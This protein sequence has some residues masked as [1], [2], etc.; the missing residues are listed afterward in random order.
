[1]QGQGE[2]RKFIPDEYPM[3]DYPSEKWWS[4][5]FFVGLGCQASG[6]CLFYSVG[7][8]HS[9]PTLWRE[10][11]IATFP[12]Q[13]VGFH[14][15]YGRSPDPQA[16]S[17]GLSHYKVLEPGQSAELCFKGPMVRSSIKELVADGPQISASELCTVDTRLTAAAPLWNMRGDSLQAQTMA[18]SIHIDQVCSF[19][20]TVRYSEFSFDITDGYAIRD[21]SRGIRDV[22]RYAGHNWLNGIFPSGR[23]FYVYM[24]KAEDGSMGMSNAAVCQGDEIYPA[25]VLHTE[26]I[27]DENGWAMGHRLVLS[28]EIGNMTV[29]F[30]PAYATVPTAMVHPYDTCAGRAKTMDISMMFD[31]ATTIRWNG[32]IGRAWTERGFSGSR[33]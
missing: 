4:E 33:G 21:H 28:S 7:R 6:F 10:N 14:R 24:M 11:I 31:E 29:D 9:D 19:E 16:V 5:N 23:A 3:Q 2:M 32:E 1:M 12:G 27:A 18:G 26:F 17:G 25:K 30:D 15:N 20:G 22:S 8:W 13:V